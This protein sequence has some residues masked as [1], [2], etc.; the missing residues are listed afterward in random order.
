[1][2]A[3][4]GIQVSEMSPPKRCLTESL[5]SLTIFQATLCGSSCISAGDQCNSFVFIEMSKMCKLNKT[6]LYEEDFKKGGGREIYIK[7]NTDGSV[8][9][10]ADGWY[11]WSSWQDCSQ[12][13]GGG[14]RKRSKIYN[15]PVNG[16]REV[17]PSGGSNA[18]LEEC[19]TQTC[20]THT[21]T[22]NP[23]NSNNPTNPADPNGSYD[24]SNP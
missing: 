21:D 4:N 19:N 13:C 9:V 3:R 18:E 24:P 17:P 16:G 2:L 1:M 11:S 5:P 6:P 15:P 20:P 22:T 10:A 12:S 23:N 14:E 7:L 8:P